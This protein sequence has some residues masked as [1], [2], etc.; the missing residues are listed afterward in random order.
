M[1]WRKRSMATIRFSGRTMNQQTAA[2]HYKIKTGK[3]ICRKLIPGMLPV[4]TER[5]CLAGRMGVCSS[6]LIIFPRGE[7]TSSVTPHL[8]QMM[9]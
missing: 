5:R 2:N 4:K 1:F 7:N 3:A 9:A 8:R 6:F